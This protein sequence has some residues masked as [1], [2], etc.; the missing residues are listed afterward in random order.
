MK[1]Y[2]REKEKSVDSIIDSRS[3]K[4]GEEEQG[5]RR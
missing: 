3:Y 5:K 1:I 2:N 4:G